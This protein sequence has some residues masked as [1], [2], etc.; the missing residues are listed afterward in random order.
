[1][2]TY[3]S[4]ARNNFLSPN[5]QKLLPLPS[6][7]RSSFPSPHPWA[8]YICSY[9]VV[10]AA[11]RSYLLPNRTTSALRTKLGDLSPLP[12]LPPPKPPLLPPQFP[13]SKTTRPHYHTHC[14]WTSPPSPLPH[15]YNHGHPPPLLHYHW[16]L[17]QQK[18]PELPPP[19]SSSL[20]PSPP[21]QL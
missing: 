5:Q 6:P 4:G 2:A 15:H 8:L 9:G 10:A 21:P 3:T 1:M 20:P 11:S 12:S 19:T 13:F 18:P 16:H 7:Q 17:S 14:P